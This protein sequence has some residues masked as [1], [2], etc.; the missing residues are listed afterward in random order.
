MIAWLDGTSAGEQKMEDLISVACS[1]GAAALNIIPDR[2][3]KPGV[4]DKKLQNL[5]DVVKLA[6]AHGLPIIVG[7]EM[8]N[9]GQ[10]FVDAF[11]TAELAP[12]APVFLK[13]AHVVYA[14]S[15]LQG[16]ARMG[17]LSPWA[18]KTFGTTAEKNEFF[19]EFGRRMKPARETRIAGVSDAM[20]AAEVLKLAGV[21]DK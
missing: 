9:P 4:K 6:E 15:V 19:A 11:E 18:R 17:Y 16:R 12:L 3:Y 8:N 14:H 5:Y 1:T 2:N 13:G 7:T 10:K 20:S 21:L